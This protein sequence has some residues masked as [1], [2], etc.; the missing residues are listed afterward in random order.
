MRK[1]DRIINEPKPIVFEFKRQRNVRFINT[2]KDG[3]SPDPKKRGGNGQSLSRFE[4]GAFSLDAPLSPDEIRQFKT[5]FGRK[6]TLKEQNE[7]NLSK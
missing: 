1:I 3:K 4:R 5:N 6:P 7:I 2:G